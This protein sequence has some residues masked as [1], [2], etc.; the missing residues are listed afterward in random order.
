MA[1]TEVAL[2][3]GELTPEDRRAL[4]RLE[5]E[6]HDALAELPREH[7]VVL[8]SRARG[9]SFEEIATQTGMSVPRAISLYADSRDR[10]QQQ[11][12]GPREPVAVQA[13]ELEHAPTSEPPV[14][15]AAI[16]SIEAQRVRRAVR[17]L[18][19]L[20]RKVISLRFGLDEREHSVRE[21]ADRLGMSRN[22]VHRLEHRALDRLRHRMTDRAAPLAA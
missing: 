2:S 1:V 8:Q 4:K 21:T 6:V 9:L 20:E 15:E 3:E 16:A 19:A 5:S 14:E 11:V 7:R 17:G 12:F 18:P 13:G 10:V 22:M